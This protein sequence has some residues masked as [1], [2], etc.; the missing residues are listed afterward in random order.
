[1]REWL[2]RSRKCGRYTSR[3]RGVRALEPRIGKMPRSINWSWKT[4][5]ILYRHRYS[6]VSLIRLRR[7]MKPVHQALLPILKRRSPKKP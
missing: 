5:L 1:M 7:E 6:R 4:K 2:S 3:R